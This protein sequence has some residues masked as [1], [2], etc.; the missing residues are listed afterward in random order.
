MRACLGASKTDGKLDENQRRTRG[1]E[2]GA[3]QRRWS[4][5]RRWRLLLSAAWIK[6]NGVPLLSSKAEKHHVRVCLLLLSLSCHVIISKT[7]QKK[8]LTVTGTG[9]H[10]DTHCQ[11]VSL[12]HA[13]G[14]LI[15]VFLEMTHI[16]YAVCM[17][18]W[19]AGTGSDLTPSCLLSS[20]L[21]SLFPELLIHFISILPLL[22]FFPVYNQMQGFRLVFQLLCS[23]LPS[24]PL[25]GIHRRPIWARGVCSS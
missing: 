8:Q 12:G 18:R 14:N 1:G 20:P 19:K 3:R 21:S 24:P 17:A 10:S 7:N 25:L 9:T 22:P 15:I 11:Y 23:R 16:P 2:R 13:R 4:H 5:R 6:T